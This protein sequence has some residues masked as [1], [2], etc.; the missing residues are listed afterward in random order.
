MGRPHK[1]SD[2]AWTMGGYGKHRRIQASDGLVNTYKFE[3]LYVAENSVFSTLTDS[4]LADLRTNA[5]ILGRT[6][7]AGEVIYAF[8][9][10]TINEVQLVSGTV[11]G[12][13][14]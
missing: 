6:V 9:M 4:K 2:I 7:F 3:L 8:D 13:Y 12:F 11:V 10:E 1:G 14:D 5:N